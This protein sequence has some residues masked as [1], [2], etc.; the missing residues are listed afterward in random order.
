M[1]SGKQTHSEEQCSSGVQ[2]IT[3]AGPRQSLLLAKGPQPA[4]VK[5]FY[6]PCIRVQSHQPKSLE[7][8]KGRVNTITISP[9]FT[10]YVFKQLIINK[11][12]VTFQYC[13]E[14]G[15]ISVCFLLTWM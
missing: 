11:P 13:P 8:Y 7:A 15:V 6:T 14:A 4:F 12:V 9:S 2:F 1:L 5:I 10:C 3:P